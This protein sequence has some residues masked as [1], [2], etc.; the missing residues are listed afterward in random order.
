MICPTRPQDCDIVS[1]CDTQI[2]AKVG[3]A[4]TT[5]PVK[6]VV[7]YVEQPDGPFP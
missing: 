5:G 1:W 3:S 2:V 6:V 7:N 4:V